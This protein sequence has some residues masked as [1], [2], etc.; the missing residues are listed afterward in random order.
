MVCSGL[1]RIA[2]LRDVQGP[3]SSLCKKIPRNTLENY[4][5]IKLPVP[6]NEDPNRPPKAEELLSAYG[7]VRGFMTRHGLPDQSRS[8]KL[9]LQDF[10][11]GKLLYCTPPPGYKGDFNQIINESTETEEEEED[12]SADQSAEQQEDHP[13]EQ[14]EDQPTE[15]EEVSKKPNPTDFDLDGVDIRTFEITESRNPNDR[16]KQ[17]TGRKHQRRLKEKQR[18]ENN[19]GV[20]LAGKNAK[21]TGINRTGKQLPTA[22]KLT[23][24]SRLEV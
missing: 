11:D 18:L 2:E 19:T 4:Y 1:I 10:V 5:G 13:T 21:Y 15:Q 23:K 12:Q 16:R 22:V 6:Q 9:I 14:E 8:G 7:Y 3:V 20:Y 24:G 17:E